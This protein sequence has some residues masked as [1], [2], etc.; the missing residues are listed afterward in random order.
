MAICSDSRVIVQ[1]YKIE[2]KIGKSYAYIYINHIDGGNISI[3]I[4]SIVCIMWD[5][6]IEP[7][8]DILSVKH[9]DT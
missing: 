4:L 3:A 8:W 9:R 6:T 7:F 1:L 2:G 5:K